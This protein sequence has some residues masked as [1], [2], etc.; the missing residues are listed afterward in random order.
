MHVLHI[1]EMYHSSRCFS[2]LT[3][4]PV[5]ALT[6]HKGSRGP[7]TTLAS[8]DAIEPRHVCDTERLGATQMKATRKTNGK[9]RQ[10]SPASS[11]G[12]GSFLI[13]K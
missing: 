6:D 10:T 3:L 13:N 5:L 8:A 12:G 7:V 9:H 4:V 11:G 2:G 1:Q